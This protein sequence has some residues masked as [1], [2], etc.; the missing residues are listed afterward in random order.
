[1]GTL[2][3]GV[4][5]HNNLFKLKRDVLIK[6]ALKPCNAKIFKEGEPI[7]ALDARANAAEEWVQSVAHKAEAPMDW[8]YSGGIA[9]VLYLGN[10]KVRERVD[11]AIDELAD[12]LDGQILNRFGSGDPGLYRK[13]VTEV[14][15]NTI[16]AFYE[17]GRKGSTFIKK[18][19]DPFQ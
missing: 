14:P 11:R 18:K 1:M 19:P 2:D 17:P 16:A 13:G 5:Y 7:V 15:K 10:E 4:F 6:M 8:H 3:M 9:N 12:S